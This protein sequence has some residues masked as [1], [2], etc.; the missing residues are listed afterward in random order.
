M[1]AAQQPNQSDNSAGILWGVAA[2]FAFIGFIWFF[3]K[4]K[5]IKFYLAIKLYEVAMLNYIFSW[6]RD[7]E[8]FETLNS[9][10]LYAYTHPTV[11]TFT[12]LTRLGVGVGEYIRIPLVILLFGLAIFVYIGNTARLYRREYKMLELARLEKVNWPQITP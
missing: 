10:L 11:T 3:F 12:D 9:A 6:W 5:I 7:P 4:V 8:H 2:L 1:A